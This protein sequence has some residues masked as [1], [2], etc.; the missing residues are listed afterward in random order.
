MNRS[1][2]AAAILAGLVWF[3][4]V[5]E[6]ARAV[7]IPGGYYAAFDQPVINAYVATRAGGSPLLADDGLGG[8]TFTIQPYLDTGASG[9]LL[10]DETY[11]ALSQPLNNPPE[12]GIA[13]SRY[14][15]N[16][17]P[18]VVYQDVGV[19]GSD[20]FNVSQP[21]YMGLAKNTATVDLDNPQT[22]TTVYN[23]PVGPV[24][25]QIGQPPADP[26]DVLNEFD[27]IGT[28]G[29]QGKVVVMDPKPLDAYV[30]TGDTD[31]LASMNNYIYNP[32]TPFNP[33]T[34]D[35]EPGIPPTNRHIRLSYSNL[36][37]FTQVTPTGAPGPNLNDNPFIGPNPVAAMDGITTD[38]TPGVTVSFGGQQA[39]GSFLFDTG[40]ATSIIST[41]IAAKLHVRYVAGT[42]GTSNPDL[43]TFNPANPSQP[44][45]LIANQFT[46]Q[47]SGVGG[48]V[49]DAGF[50]LDNM[51]LRTMEAN[52]GNAN[53]PNNLNFV[54]APVLVDDITVKDPV[55]QKTLT[56][57]GDFGVNNYV[58]TFDQDS[59]GLPNDMAPGNFNWAVFDQPN[60][61]LGLD[62]KPDF[63]GSGFTT[64]S[65]WSSNGTAGPNWSN[66]ANWETGTPAA[67]NGL[68]F[69]Q[70]A[71]TTTSN[72]ND[73]PDGTRFNGIVFS[74]PT[75]FNLQGHRVALWGNLINIST[76]AQTVSLDL[77]LD[78]AA[79]TFDADSGDIIVSGHIS[80]PQGLIKTGDY[81]LVLSGT[82]TYTGGTTVSGGEL[83]AMSS[84]AL[85]DGGN[86]T[87]GDTTAFASITGAW[88]AATSGT[89][90]NGNNWVSQVRPNGAGQTAILNAATNTP[91]TITLDAPQTFG[92]LV[93][94]NSSSSSAGYIISGTSASTRLTFNGLGIGGT[95]TVSDGQHAINAPIL[96]AEDLTVTSDDSNPW[97]LT[98][99]TAGGIAES[100]HER[101]TLNAPDGKL[102]LSGTGGYT[103]G[104]YVTAGKLIV[105]RAAA[106][107][108]RTDLTIGDASLFVPVA[109]AP[110]V[111]TAAVPEP[112]T[113]ALLAV[114][115]ALIGLQKKLFAHRS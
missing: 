96:L 31:S 95:I 111:T 5:A 79:S 47:I 17:G 46:L 90:S 67:A 50:Y 75:S 53:D 18:L 41:N 88:A 66:S 76:A 20:N 102:I 43:E 93:F 108:D 65:A 69:T 80:G 34:A 72:Y 54:G 98:F 86:L 35:S 82:N 110:A 56:L 4:F 74:G 77:E 2:C 24:R 91:L 62:V 19:G 105:T 112:G 38:H 36:N 49:T 48:A 23:Q 6:A 68:R 114:G 11:T 85:P 8:Q 84:K 25:V 13:K 71:G 33:A 113:L 100:G 52:P 57:D 27:V 81:R 10:S 101:L 21:I 97:I 15:A 30:T 94:G 115:A 89:W 28:P 26:L 61:V 40:A 51:L 99:G 14:P 22:Y 37:R 83:I 45:T 32:R 106:I 107:A 1:L 12:A 3:S 55:T 70:S 29:M 42:Q 59:E 103:G 64:F 7:D 60:G 58:A 44:G 87:V 16:T 104:T 109:L 92:A 9:I 78:G 73:F 63:I 39:T